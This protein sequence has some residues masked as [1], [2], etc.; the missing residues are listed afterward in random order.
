[1]LANSYPA[2]G[3]EESK[4]NPFGNS[5]LELHKSTNFGNGRKET[6]ITGYLL[7][8]NHCTPITSNPHNN[9]L[10]QTK[11]PFLTGENFKLREIK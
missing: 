1:M 6:S 4:S 10:R 2:A 9:P 7:Y 11:Y 8:A 5:S 3:N